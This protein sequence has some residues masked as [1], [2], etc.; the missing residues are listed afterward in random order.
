MKST[1]LTIFILLS[2]TIALA[3]Y[4]EA[5]PAW[6]RPVEPFKI[7]GNIYYVGANEITSYLIT[8]PRGH[9]LL[10]S[11][12]RET[13]PQIMSNIRGLGF[14]PTDVKFLINSQAHYD[15]AGGMAELRRLTKAKIL[16]SKGDSVLMTNGGKGDPNFGDRYTFEPAVAD[17]IFQD[18]YKLKL[19]KTTLTANITPGHTPGCTTWTL[20]VNEGGRDHDVVFVC[21]TSAPGYKLVENPGY[22]SIVQD[23]NRSFEWLRSLKPEIFLAAHGSMFDLSAKIERLRIGSKENPFVDPTGY[24]AYVSQS[25]ASFRRML[26]VQR[27]SMEAKPGDQ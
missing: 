24:E 15:H 2:S 7:A 5:D 11:G 21:S 16:I 23:F 4:T 20:T 27:E 22:P 10:D 3:Q 19:G 6:N 25:E 18:G 8:T 13:V 14:E 26:K 1:L 9:I 12:F 17:L